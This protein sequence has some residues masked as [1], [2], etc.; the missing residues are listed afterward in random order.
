MYVHHTVSRVDTNFVNAVY[1]GGLVFE[2]RG[3]SN[4]IQRFFGTK[5]KDTSIES[6]KTFDPSLKI[7]Y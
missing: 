6:I 3:G 1:I 2:N 4:Q 5:L 7:K